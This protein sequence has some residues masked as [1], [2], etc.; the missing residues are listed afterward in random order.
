MKRTIFLWTI[1]CMELFTLE[2]S[3]QNGSDLKNLQNILM[4]HKW[5]T[6]D[7]YN[8]G[9]SGFITY[10]QTKEIDS[11]T[12][13]NK[14]KIYIATYYFSNTPDLVFDKNKV[15]KAVAGKYLIMNRSDNPE[16]IATFIYEIIELS[17][18][19]ITIKHLTPNMTT[20]GYTDT[21]LSAPE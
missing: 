7:I 20:Y 4:S 6:Q 14:L 5:I 1:I 12:I 11:V 18:K 19:E 9:E 3:G 13:D 2:S 17:E 15:G 16:I 21:Y 8:E 10:T